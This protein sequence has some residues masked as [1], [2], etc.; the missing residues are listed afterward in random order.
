[1]VTNASMR[2]D[3]SGPDTTPVTAL[4]DEAVIQDADR[5]SR[6]WRGDETGDVPLGSEAHKRLFS[7]LLLDTYNPYKPAIIEWPKLSDAERDRL[8]KLPIWD[9][10][11][12]TEGKARMR[13]LGYAETVADPLVRKALELNG[14]EEGRHKEVLAHMVAAYGIVLEPEP[15]Y[16]KPRD[17]EW[18]Y[19]RTGFSECIDSF[20]AFGLF[21]LARQSGFFPPA[22]VA[23]FE[24]VMQEECRH[25]LFFSNWVAW[26]R[27]NLP[28]WKRP[29]FAFRVLTVWAA[30]VWE[31]LKTAR[32]VGGGDNFT[33]S[34]H[35]AMGFDADFKDLMAVCLSENERRMRGY[36]QRL[37]RPAV[38]PLLARTVLRF[39]G[40]RAQPA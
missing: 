33:A 27:R 2:Q 28:L 17:T 12:Q 24:P 15:E 16:L 9:I 21:E 38:M 6:N 36:D 39:T 34:G 40:R 1:M 32:D 26:H 37:V 11:V 3:D 20:F 30:L 35:E 23:T 13:M 18:S 25:I 22:L 14:F 29:I 7:R 31:R 4:P 19:M 8:V 5:A 10:A